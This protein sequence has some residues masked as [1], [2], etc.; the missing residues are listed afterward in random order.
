YLVLAQEILP[1]AMTTGSIMMGRAL[2]P[3]EGAIGNWRGFVMARGAFKRVAAIL[4]EPVPNTSQLNLPRPAGDLGVEKLVATAP[5]E[6]VPIIKG[7]SFGSKAGE[8]LGIVGPS[9]AGKSTLARLLVGVWPPSS[10]H[11]RLD[12]ADVSTWNHTELGKHI[13]YLSQEAELF[14]GTVSENISRFGEAES[15]SVIEAAKLAGVH[16]LV[17]RLPDGYDTRIGAGGTVLSGGQRQRI[18]LARAVYGVPSF[19]VLDEPNAN[20]DKDGELALQATIQELRRRGTSVVVIAHRSALVRIAD[21]ILVLNE[22]KIEHFG[23]R[24]EVLAALAPSPV[25]SQEN[26]VHKQIDIV[27]SGLR[28]A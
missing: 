15:Q 1:G 27:N 22:G 23:L 14:D 20:L 17:L 6:N 21:R 18:G 9:A 11:V 4:S 12:G 7:I 24:E 13:G 28:S 3:V 10:G 8:V 16:D 19:V 26:P 25:N 2:A 5:G